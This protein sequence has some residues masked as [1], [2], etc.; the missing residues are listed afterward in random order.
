MYKV[1]RFSIKSFL[2]GSDV[3]KVDKSKFIS[4]L[5]KCKSISVDGSDFRDFKFGGISDDFKSYVSMIKEKYPNGYYD[6]IGSKIRVLGFDEL[7]KMSAS[8]QKN[9][10]KMRLIPIFKDFSHG[11]NT[12]WSYIPKENEIY[13]FEVEPREYVNPIFGLAGI[14]LLESIKSLIK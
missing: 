3:T 2:L 8:L 4:D 6:I 9:F 14:P 10:N 1:K 11:F 5:D 12:Y 13:L 7:T